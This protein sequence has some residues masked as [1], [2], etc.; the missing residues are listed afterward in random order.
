MQ[1]NKQG[2]GI[3]KKEILEYWDH[4]AKELK[5]SPQATMGDVNLRMLEIDLLL[6]HLDEENHVL[7]VGCGNG[8]ATVIFSKNVKSIVGIDFSEEMVNQ[9]EATIKENPPEKK[10]LSF[11]QMDVLNLTYPED[12]FDV[13]ISERCLINLRSWEDQQGAMLEIKRVLKEGGKFLMIEGTNEGLNELNRMRKYYGLHEIIKHWHNLLLD[14]DKLMDFL[15]E[16]FKIM[17]IRSLGTYYFVSRVVHPL[18]VL[19]DE[20][21]FEAKINEVARR[22]AFDIPDFD[23]ISINKL[24]VL[25]K[26]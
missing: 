16:N 7:D 22:L 12:T 25:S 18:V 10:N 3:D 14:N 8:F 4:K 21:K 9:A 20:P 24:Y 1:G 17:E 13:A 23:D 15:N 6:T 26:N 2:D 19:P 11:K 5:E